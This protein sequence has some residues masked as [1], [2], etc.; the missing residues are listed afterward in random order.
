VTQ[1]DLISGTPRYMAPE[2]WQGLAHAD[3]RSDIYALGVVAY[4]CLSGR[5][6][7]EATGA[8]AW[9]NK[10]RYEAPLEL[11]DAMAGRPVPRGM[12]D[13]VMKALRKDPAARP[14]T[15]MALWTAMSAGL[16]AAVAG[17]DDV[18]RRRV[19][20]WIPAVAIP[21]A[22]A[23][24]LAWR[25]GRSSSGGGGAC[26]PLAGSHMPLGVGN[27]WRY[28]VIDPSTNRP[29]G[30]EK[31][32][33]IDLRADIGGRKAGTIGFRLVRTDALGGA[34]R[35]LGRSGDA[36]VWHHD[37]W[38]DPAGQLT[39]SVY[40]EPWK[41]R[42]DDAC[43]H[44]ALRARWAIEYETIDIDLDDPTRVTATPVREEWAVEAIDE[45]VVVPAGTFRAMRLR[46]SKLSNAV[47]QDSVFWFTP[48]I[49]KIKE[50]SPE[51]L[52]ELVAYQL[53]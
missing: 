3:A 33:S 34:V 13:A 28:R 12:R 39:R 38:F 48:G 43:T 27:S 7:L 52:D 36:V 40:Y 26:P 37:E 2:Q 6:P 1:P 5:L 18:S 25:F 47:R 21:L 50:D 49:G 14:A 45:E 8:L 41:L 16:D 20:R 53:A 51:A 4:E 10:H 11:D 35:W 22:A 29:S 46:R 19:L 30:G 31:T 32:I 17:G 42:V 24:G 44:R 23:G 15:A 9:L